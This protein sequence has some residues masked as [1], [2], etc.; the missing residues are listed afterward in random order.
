MQYS[1]VNKS[2]NAIELALKN[3]KKQL[4]R[5]QLQTLVLRRTAPLS[6]LGIAKASIETAT[7]RISHQQVSV[8]FWFICVGP[9]F[10]LAYRLCYEASQTWNIKLPTFHRFGWMAAQICLILQ[11]LPTRLYG[12]LLALL[13]LSMPPAILFK[14]LFS[15]NSLM[16]SNGGFLLSAA[17]L[18]LN[19]HLS[20]AVI[21]D[22]QKCRRVKYLGRQEPNV[23][24]IKTAQGANTKAFFA[25]LVIMLLISLVIN[26]H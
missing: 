3:Q 15:F 4:A 9:I 6:S 8:M 25:M 1:G 13:S 17:G 19:R 24:D 18:A 20:G 5:D 23:E 22:S 14:R 12:I 16:Q 26:K 2:V 21:Y 7:L 10:A 11:W